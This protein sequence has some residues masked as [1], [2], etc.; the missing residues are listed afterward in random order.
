M[1]WG[2]AVPTPPPCN[3]PRLWAAGV[4]HVPLRRR[5]RRFAQLQTDVRFFSQPETNEIFKSHKL[6]SQTRW[7]LPVH[8][9]VFLKGIDL[10]EKTKQNKTK[11]L[12]WGETYFQTFLADLPRSGVP[13]QRLHFRGPSHFP[14]FALPGPIAPQSRFSRSS[15]PLSRQCRNFGRLRRVPVSRP[16]GAQHQSHQIFEAFGSSF[17]VDG[18]EGEAG[19]N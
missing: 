14:A 2:P 1:I 3:L 19:V 13:L 18:Q 10:K 17:R 11:H 7:R 12:E 15:A 9:F 16:R 6:S 5:P 8:I 4:E